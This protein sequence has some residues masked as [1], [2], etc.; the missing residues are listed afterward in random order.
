[1][2]PKEVYSPTMIFLAGCRQAEGVLRR[3][4]LDRLSET[5]R[6]SSGGSAHAPSVLPA[7]GGADALMCMYVHEGGGSPSGPNTRPALNKL[8]FVARWREEGEFIVAW[9]RPI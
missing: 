5:N 6:A 3:G 7:N 4:L 2:T 1:V 9:G 8:K